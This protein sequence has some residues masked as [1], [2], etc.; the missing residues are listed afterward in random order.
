MSEADITALES[1]LRTAQRNADVVT[2][3]RLIAENLLFTGPDGALITKADDLAAYRDGILRIIGYE[4]EE[5]QIRRVSAEIF[6][7]ALRVQL[8]GNYAGAPFKSTAHY[9]RIWSRCRDSG[10]WQ[11]VGGHVSLLP[12]AAAYQ[13]I[14][15]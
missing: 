8:A 6:L 10:R 2:L 12:S 7:V 1:E 14:H 11:I 3:D 9:T 4:T 15:I 5:L 13:L